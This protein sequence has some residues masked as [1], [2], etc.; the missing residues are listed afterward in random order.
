MLGVLFVIGGLVG[1]GL[2]GGWLG[3]EMADDFVD[4]WSEFPQFLAGIG[5]YVLWGVFGACVGALSAPLTLPLLILAGPVYLGHR[6]YFNRK[7]VN[8]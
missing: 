7:K 2:A 3:R 1:A 8:F 6:Y 4:D 5:C